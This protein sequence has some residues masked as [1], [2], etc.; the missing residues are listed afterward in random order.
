[1]KKIVSLLFS[2]KEGTTWR[3]VQESW[4]QREAL[5]YSIDQPQTSRS[6][7]LIRSRPAEPANKQGE[8]GI[9]RC[10][11]QDTSKVPGRVVGC[12]RYREKNGPTDKAEDEDYSDGD[13][14]GLTTIRVGGK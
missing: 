6:L 10:N 9:P 1:M 2:K 7:T 3:D 13:A 8:V 14:S 4:S 11:D 5:P 12:S